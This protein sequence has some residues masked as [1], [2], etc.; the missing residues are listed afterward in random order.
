[1]RRKSFEIAL[2]AV[3]SSLAVIFLTF[4]AFVPVFDLTAY[5]LSSIAL[6]LPLAKKFYLGGFLSY[7]SS[8]LLALLITGGNFAFVL[9]FFVF[10]GIHALIN[11]FQIKFNINKYLALVIKIIWFDLSLILMYKFTQIFISDN[12]FVIDYVL[13]YIYYFI[14]T[15]GSLFFIF[16]DWFIFRA[17]R[18]INIF[19][20]KYKK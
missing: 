18:I 12:Q 13:K 1:M 19:V 6:M 20:E 15:L 4:G 17:Q 11:S 2:S 3:A 10:F 8:A 14:P 16:Y 7:L 5:M 9:P